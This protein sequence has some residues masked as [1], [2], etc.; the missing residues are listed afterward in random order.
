MDHFEPL[1]THREYPPDE[2]L[3]RA[4]EFAAELARRRTTRHF[5]SRAVERSVIEHCLRAAGSAPSGAHRQPWHFVVISNPELKRRIREATEAAEREFYA[6]GPAEWLEALKPLGT[7]ASKPYLET[8]PYLIAVFAE[9]YRSSADGTTHKNYYVNESVGIACGF[10]IAALHHAGLA[11][12]TH[13]PNPMTFLSQLLERPSN[14]KPVMLI[15]AGFP[16][17][18]ARVPRLT[19]KDP[20]EFVT[21]R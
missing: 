16:A 7:D 14:E 4:T 8:A 20:V 9:R 11:T 12:L 5:S 1:S 10:L 3:V 13:T 21:F 2:M 17:P 6:N 15:V 18:D 19:R